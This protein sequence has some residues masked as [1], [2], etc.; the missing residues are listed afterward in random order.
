ME[1]KISFENFIKQNNLF[2]DNKNVETILKSKEVIRLKCDFEIEGTVPKNI[3]LDDQNYDMEI[4]ISDND[5]IKLIPEII[6]VGI[7]CR[8]NKD[9][10]EL[11]DFYYET[12][13]S[14][15]ISP[16]SV[17]KITSI[18]IKKDEQGL[19]KLAQK[20]NV[21][22]VTYSAEELLKAEGDFTSSGFVKSITGVDNVCERSAK[23]G[24]KNGKILLHK[25]AFNGMT[26]SVS[27]EE[28]KLKF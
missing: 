16:K 19:I 1:N 14:L 17:K 21:P 26:I 27:Q 7:G 18:D 28:Y 13:K 5:K 4:S 11:L 8:K 22:F 2:D 15:K 23:I 20:E 24:S 25:T 6:V 10:S 3:I 12:L 9:Y